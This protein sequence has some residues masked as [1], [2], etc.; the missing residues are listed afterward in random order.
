MTKPG[1]CIGLIDSDFVG[2]AHVFGFTS[3]PRVFGLPLYWNFIHSPTSSAASA[4][5]KRAYCEKVL[6]PLTR[7]ALVRATVDHGIAP[8]GS[9]RPGA[10][11]SAS[12]A[13]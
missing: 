3:A 5:G 11:T 13:R 4:A 8:D 6:A 2:K 1:L 12:A 9:I 7:D 10:T